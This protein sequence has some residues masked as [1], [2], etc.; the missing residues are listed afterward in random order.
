MRGKNKI[1]DRNTFFLSLIFLIFI[2]TGV[3]ISRQLKSDDFMKKLESNEY[4]AVSFNVKNNEKFMFSELLI[5]NPVTHK[6]AIF[7]IPGNYGSIIESLSRIE[8]LDILFNFKKP[9]KMLEKIEN[10]TSI[11]IDY[12][13]NIDSQDLV[14]VVDLLSGLEMF[15]ANPVEIINE[16]EII[17]LPS[18]SN[19]LDGEK[20]QTF[21]LTDTEDENDADLIGR[22]HKFIQA[23]IKKAGEKSDYLENDE[24]FNK[25]YSFFVTDMNKEAFK[26][27]IR[28]IKQLNSERMILQRILGDRKMIDNQ[29]ML[30]PYYNGNLLR[31]TIKQTLSSIANEDIISDEEIRIGIEI[32]NGTSI[33]GMA[34][35]TAHFFTNLGYDVISTKNAEKSD[36]EKT[37]VISMS[38]DPVPAQKIANIIRCNNIEIYKDNTNIEDSANTVNKIDVT[39]ILGKDFDGRYCK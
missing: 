34:G 5:F 30:F 32:L 13:I 21:L 39:I 8:R 10:I 4:I 11:K 19:N 25:F 29:I 31:E 26:T 20:I 27:F 6:A 14:K 24:I 28:Q 9:D 38:E 35:R 23:F 1:L 18:G 15:I 16:N 2:V 7:N 36:Y 12:F 37:V 22:W 33:P 3:Y 17:L